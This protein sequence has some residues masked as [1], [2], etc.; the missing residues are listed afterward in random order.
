MRYVRGTQ[1]EHARMSHL[2][3]G[4]GDCA[5]GL[6]LPIG[7]IDFRKCLLPGEG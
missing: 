1:V 2:R 7:S 3:A 4:C 5:V 6:V